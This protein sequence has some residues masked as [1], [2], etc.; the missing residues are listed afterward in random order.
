MFSMSWRGIVETFVEEE[1][2]IKVDSEDEQEFAQNLLTTLSLFI[3]NKPALSE[4]VLEVS[5]NHMPEGVNCTINALVS[6][7]QQ[8]AEMMRKDREAQ[9]AR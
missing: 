3:S 9:V 4:A 8:I 7:N 1:V 2:K 5:G 6:T